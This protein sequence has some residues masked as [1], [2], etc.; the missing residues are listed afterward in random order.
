MKLKEPV[1]NYYKRALEYMLI[2]KDADFS[3]GLCHALC[4]AVDSKK[5]TVDTE[6]NGKS[7]YAVRDEI[8]PEG[9]FKE[10][11]AFK[12]RNVSPSSFWF[13]PG[14]QGRNRRIEILREI[15]KKLEDETI[16]S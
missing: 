6:Y 8:T 4:V 10:L 13:Y 9:F 2:S 15:I 1:I 11:Y 3:T 16:N 12:P 14:E 7:F 5:I